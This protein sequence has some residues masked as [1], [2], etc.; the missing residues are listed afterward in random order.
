MSLRLASPLFKLGNRLVFAVNGCCW[1]GPQKHAR[2]FLRTLLE[3]TPHGA[4]MQC[5]TILQNLHRCAMDEGKLP[6]IFHIGADNTP[7]E[8]KNGTM[9]NFL[10]WLLCSLSETCLWKV[11][12]GF[13]LVGHTHDNLDRFYSRLCAA[14]KGKN[15]FTAAEMHQIVIDSMP[16]QHVEWGHLCTSWNFTD[17][18]A[19]IG[20]EA[21]KLRNVHDLVL[22]R[23]AAGVHVQWKQWLTCESYSKPLL[24]VPSDKMAAVASLVPDA[25]VHKFGALHQSQITSWLQK[26]NLHLQATGE[27]EDCKARMDWLHAAVEQRADIQ[28]Q[29][30]PISCIIADLQNLAGGALPQRRYQNGESCFPD[31]VLAQ[32]HPGADVSGTPVN[33]LMHIASPHV[34]LPPPKAN[35]VV[36]GSLVVVRAP[37]EF[38]ALPFL[39]ATIVDLI[40]NQEA[41]VQ[42]HVPRQSKEVNFRAGR[43]KARWGAHFVAHQ[44]VCVGQSN[45][46]CFATL[47]GSPRF[48]RAMGCR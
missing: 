10:V 12:L 27:A 19:R 9:I 34:Q 35:A 26:F 23:D 33:S 11:Q 21:K 1:S 15:Y 16:S 48:V 14:L 5:S 4:D 41:L 38:K 36:P 8:T 43:K 31:D 29:C 13:M 2:W 42:W 40:N 25:I 3:D 39:M 24:L 37:Q 46:S 6:R 18:R 20:L 47:A 32:L 17:L 45:Q 22:F 28:Q 7:K 30:L 44:F